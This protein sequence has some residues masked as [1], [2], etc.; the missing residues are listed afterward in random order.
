MINNI[1]FHH[2]ESPKIF[3]EVLPNLKAP[4]FFWL[5]AHWSGGNTFGEKA[6]CPL[7][8]ELNE[9]I[10]YDLP[11]CLFIDD[12]RLFISPP[13]FP[14]ERRQWPDL[15][16][17]VGILATGK[18]KRRLLL[19]EDVL[20]AYPENLDDLIKDWGQKHIAAKMDAISQKMQTVVD[21]K[22]VWKMKHYGLNSLADLRRV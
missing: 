18:I 14:L 5:D 8:G 22:I 13:P 15:N 20:I 10:K 6:Q 1:S 3:S 2:G 21:G 4:R 19:L 16:D 11:H 12:A 9:I 17:I 7:V